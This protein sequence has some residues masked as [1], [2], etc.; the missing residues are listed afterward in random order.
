MLAK[1]TVFVESRTATAQ[2]WDL[3]L[4]RLSHSTITWPSYMPG[5][6]SVRCWHIASSTPCTCLLAKMHNLLICDYQGTLVNSTLLRT[7]SSRLVANRKGNFAQDSINVVQFFTTL[8]D[9]GEYATDLSLFIPMY[10][11]PCFLLCLIDLCPAELIPGSSF[12]SNTVP[13]TRPCATPLGPCAQPLYQIC[14]R[15][16]GS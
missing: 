10:V 16:K 8:F 11:R 5:I 14:Q 13:Q 9:S 1:V 2:E 7:A 15:E 6:H 3:A 4:F 12:C